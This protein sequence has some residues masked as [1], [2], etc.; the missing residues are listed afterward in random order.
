MNHVL[1]MAEI[2]TLGLLT[3]ITGTSPPRTNRELFLPPLD[4]D[5]NMPVPTPGPIQT[6]L[7]TPLSTSTAMDSPPSAGPGAYDST[8]IPPSH[9]ARTL[10]LCFDGT[11]DQFDTDVRKYILSPSAHVLLTD[12]MPFRIPISYSYSRC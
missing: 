4:S 1:A 2:S 12:Q 11:G 8:V 10:V 6:N 9:S 3:L 5:I 7:K